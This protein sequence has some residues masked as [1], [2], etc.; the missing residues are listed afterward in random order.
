[1][2]PRRQRA[3][4][5]IVQ[6]VGALFVFI[7]ATLIGVERSSRFLTSLPS[8]KKRCQK[9]RSCVRVL[10]LNGGKRSPR[11]LSLTSAI[12]LRSNIRQ[13]AE[14]DIRVEG[15]MASCL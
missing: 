4:N 7:G 5:N 14:L 10:T 2:R 11:S 6:A 13:L 8:S 12:G 15:P 1:M 3:P 9:P